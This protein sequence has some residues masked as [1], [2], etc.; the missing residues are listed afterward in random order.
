[1]PLFALGLNHLS[2]PLEVR[3]RVAFPTEGLQQALRD[4]R[5][6]PGVGEAAIV[7]TCNRTELYVAGAPELAPQALR[8]WLAR[9]HGLGEDWLSPYLYTHLDAEAVRHLIRVSAGLDSMV[10]GEPQILGQAKT[11]YMEAGNAGTLGRVLERAF[12]HAFAVA[13][14]VRTD[15]A[16]GNSPV[17]VAFAAVS[18]AH[19]IFGDLEDNSALLIGAGETIELTARHLREH[20]LGRMVIANRTV[21][22]AQTLANEFGATAI[23]L[24][25]IPEY[26][27]G[28]DIVIAST[29]SSL[30]ILGKG[31]V[32]RALKARRR[33]PM[34]MVDIAV[35]RDIE[36][37]VGELND[38]YLYTVDDLKEVV[39]DNLRSRR[40]AAAQAEEIVAE[41]VEHYMRWLRAQ[42]AIGLLRDYR[43]RAARHRDEILARAL[44]RLKH[45]ESPEEA[46]AYLANTLTNRLIHAP[47]VGLREAAGR[48]DK[49]MLGAAKTLLDIDDEEAQN[50]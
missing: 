15:T 26:L 43:E 46:L 38:V 25:D 39:E 5:A 37:E 14:Q 45:G 17:S 21:E 33:K 19:Q 12:Q 47:T 3:E 40:E 34:F 41:Q 22:R 30:P 44:K 9:S 18:L 48:G 29:A 16:I 28:S 6:V 42:D 50:P 11:A 31:S 24:G 1:M 36:A 32:E 23:T 20:G 35:P 10:L 13:K 4:L 27:A 2:A 8:S 49:N 7:S